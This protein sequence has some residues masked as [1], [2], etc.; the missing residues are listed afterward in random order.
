[1]TGDVVLRQRLLDEQQPERIEPGQMGRITERVG[2]VGVDLEEHLVTEALPHG[3]D[4]VDVPTGLDLELDPPI[5]GADVAI[6]R[7]EQLGDAGHDPDRDAAVDPVADG[8]EVGGERAS[9][10]PQLGVEHGHLECGLGHRMTLD[11]RQPGGNARRGQRV[12]GEQPGEQE[13]PDR[14]LGAVDVLGGVQRLLHG[15]A[16][17]PTFGVGRG[18]LHQQC[19]AFV[20]DAERRAERGDEGQPNPAQLDLVELHGL[21]RDSRRYQPSRLMPTAT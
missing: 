14:I 1:M 9:G 13:A 2:A 19:V 15:D 11:R 18:H 20:L 8:A 4:R 5:A 7:V 16:L 17:A 21:A 3:G 6:D 12:G 10:G